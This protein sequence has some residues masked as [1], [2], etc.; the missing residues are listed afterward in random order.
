MGELIGRGLGERSGV[1]GICLA[2]WG[3]GFW[4]ESGGVG[5]GEL[6]AGGKG[7]VGLKW[8]TRSGCVR[9]YKRFGRPR[10]RIL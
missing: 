10:F 2:F 8:V 3:V 4:E 7:G 9:V 6:L 1:G 5:I